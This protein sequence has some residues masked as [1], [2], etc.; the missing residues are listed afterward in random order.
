MA[1]QQCEKAARFEK[2]AGVSV[3]E[4]AA[5][6]IRAPLVQVFGRSARSRQK[7]NLTPEKQDGCK[8]EETTRVRSPALG[9]SCSSGRTLENRSWLRTDVVVVGG[10]GSDIGQ[11]RL[12]SQVALGLA[13]Y[14]VIEILKSRPGTGT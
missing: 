1:V 3:S 6:A 10:C 9:V 14:W 2:I 4:F 11:R 12:V 8:A 7:E 13:R 5:L